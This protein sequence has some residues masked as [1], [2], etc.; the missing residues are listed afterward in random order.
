MDLLRCFS[1]RVRASLSVEESTMFTAHS[2]A[3]NQSLTT[4]RVWRL[5]RRSTKSDGFLSRMQPTSCCPPTVSQSLWSTRMPAVWFS[6][7]I[8]HAR[9]PSQELLHTH[10]RNSMRACKQ[11]LMSIVA[12]TS[13]DCRHHAWLLQNCKLGGA[14]GWGSCGGGLTLLTPIFKP[15]FFFFF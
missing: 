8:L 10:L 15:F 2:R 5:R 12:E 3:T 7:H 13:P 4:W 14:D 6:D 1:R 11:T 9:L